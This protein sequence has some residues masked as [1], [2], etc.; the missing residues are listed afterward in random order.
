MRDAFA[1]SRRANAPAVWN[2]ASDESTLCALPSVSDTLMSTTRNPAATPRSIWARTP[3]STDGMNEFGIAP[4]TIRSANSNPDPRAS[5]STSMSHTA[6]CPCPPDCFTCRP[7]PLAGLPNVSRS[8]TTTG[9]VSSSTPC[10]R[11]RSSSTSACASPIHH[12][13]SWWVSAL[14][15]SRRV[16]SPAVS[17][18]RPLARASSSLRVLAATATGSSGSGMSQA[19]TS[20]GSSLAEIVS[21]VSAVDTFVTAHMSPATHCETGRSVA[22]SGEK[23]WPIRSSASWS[24]AGSQFPRAVAAWPDT[25]T[26]R[27]GR[28]VPENTRTS[29]TRPT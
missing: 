14:R 1:A 17:L 23:M 10:S 20:S 25:W 7:W 8:G 19:P 4:P 22:P 3:F 29:E 24:F 12:S 26:A 9:T 2:A 27:S 11:S 6:Y 18:P 13:T 21:P 5:G 16:G 15:S 28:S